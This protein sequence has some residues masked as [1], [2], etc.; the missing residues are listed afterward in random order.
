MGTNA[1]GGTASQQVAASNAGADL[2][3]E[4]DSILGLPAAQPNAPKARAGVATPPPADDA[5]PIGDDP[6]GL[7]AEGQGMDPNA[8]DGAGDE[9]EPGDDEDGNAEEAPKSKVQKRIDELTAARK[10]AEE[11][12]TTVQQQALVLQQQLALAQQ[13]LAA[14]QAGPDTLQLSEITDPA[15]FTARKQ[16][17]EQHLEHWQGVLESGE[18]QDKD[19]N[20]VELTPERKRLVAGYVRDLKR[21]LQHHV[22]QREKFFAERAAYEAKAQQEFPWLADQ[23]SAK[24]RA[25][26]Q[27]LAQFPEVGPARNRAYALLVGYVVEGMAA[28]Q[29]AQA[30]AGA[31]APRPPAAPKAAAGPVVQ[32]PRKRAAA[33]LHKR[34]QQTGSEEDLAAIIEAEG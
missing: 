12:L 13:A 9:P 21:S 27:L 26:Q 18:E 8:D 10:T 22:P 32:P 4:V 16:Q 14:K 23:N 30:P 20:A 7:D 6:E 19:G 15:Q 31:Q 29:Q 1:N 25:A 24:F 34:F 33:P 5:D 17:I 11:R 2:S 28:R 3:L